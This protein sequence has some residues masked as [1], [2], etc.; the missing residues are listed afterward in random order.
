MKLLRLALSSVLAM[1][2]ITTVTVNAAYAA[3]VN[4]VT[5]AKAVKKCT[6]T[7]KAKCKSKGVSKQKVGKKDLSGI[8]LSKGKITKSK[9]TG[10]KMVKADFSG[11]TIQDT[12]FSGT[13]L[14]DANFNGATLKNVTFD[15]GADMRSV[16][17]KGAKL[18]NV[19]IKG[20]TLGSAFR[21][22][23]VGSVNQI[24]GVT[25]ANCS[26]LDLSDSRIE[27]MALL[28]S[29]SY[30]MNLSGATIVSMFVHLSDVDR[31]NF[32]SA[33]IKYI[34]AGG[35]SFKNTNFRG[36]TCAEDALSVSNTNFS[37]SRWYDAESSCIEQIKNYEDE[38][39]YLFVGAH[40][41]D[42]HATMDFRSTGGFLPK[43]ISVSETDG[44]HDY[45]A[46]CI[47]TNSC[48]I[49]AQVGHDITA[50]IWTV[51]ALFE[52]NSSF[53]TCG[54][55]TLNTF[56]TGARYLYTCTAP[57]SAVVAGASHDVR[58]S[59]GHTVRVEG[60]NMFYPTRAQVFRSLAIISNGTTVKTCSNAS[61]CVA[62][63]ARGA[64][65]RIRVS[66]TLGETWISQTAP[67][68]N[69]EIFTPDVNHP[70]GV[71]S[72]TTS[73]V[74]AS[75]NPVFRASVSDVP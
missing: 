26:G 20:V 70:N 55:P 63:V 56:V 53:L 18:T 25:K 40:G 24:C 60:V 75:G 21:I 13:N 54:D 28:L 9:F 74:V 6:L 42:G 64:L 61:V 41:L 50:R 52:M 69:S 35:S 7:K 38:K 12:T 72:G 15:S 37:G 68:E 3:P 49:N 8:K 19:K 44:T 5:K 43:Q 73:E 10:T 47:Y 29:R 58:Y 65:V 45:V 48:K 39:P 66:S 31:T 62:D 34:N 33:T 23:G 36:A 14:N 30:E 1:A 27:G 51:D 59:D 11:S 2:L 22:R 71:Y 46:T 4:I 16:S 17:F 32:D 67:T 57:A